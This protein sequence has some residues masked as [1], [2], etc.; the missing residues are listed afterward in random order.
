MELRYYINKFSNLRVH[1]RDG[2]PSVHKPSMLLAVM[3][4][5]RRGELTE[6]RIPY[7]D[8]LKKAFTKRFEQLSK[9]E[10]QDRPYVPYYY[11]RDKGDDSFWHHKVRESNAAE[12]EAFSSNNQEK[13]I[14]V[15]IEYATVD[16]EL[17]EYFKSPVAREVLQV[18]LEEGLDKNKETK[19]LSPRQAWSWHECEIIVA[20]YFVMLEKEINGE[21]YNKAAHRRAIQKKLDN[22][23]DGSIER[24]HQNISAIL[25][26]ADMPAIDGY[27]PLLN[28]QRMLRD[29]V[30]AKLAESKSLE[31]AMRELSAKSRSDIPAIPDDLSCLV[32]PPA[33]LQA[34]GSA[35]AAEFDMYR[36]KKVDFVAEQIKNSQL[37]LQGEKYILQFEKIRLAKAG[38]E[39]LSE[40]VS[41][42]GQDNINL[43]YDIHSYDENGKDRFIEVKTTNY[44][45]YTR[46]YVTKN[47]LKVSEKLAR[48]YHLYRVYLFNEDPPPFYTRQGQIDK[49]FT[50]HPSNFT[51]SIR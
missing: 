36:P 46:F 33:M 8:Q 34:K 37:G 14:Q 29:V 47:E 40:Q 3:D 30:S 12:Y 44:G 41:H 7:N 28:Y 45:R 23:P 22:R 27:K 18:A 25:M 10:G 6:N 49:N 35:R 32:E 20:D 17:F 13:K 15:S 51:A 21:K 4:M 48:Q 43:G 2:K 9:G 24:K 26:E 38:K 19:I 1:V 5:V 11:L 31:Q 42:V 39:V 50:L 16:S